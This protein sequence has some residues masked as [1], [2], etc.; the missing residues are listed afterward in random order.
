MIPDTDHL[1]TLSAA[2]REVPNRDSG[3]GVNVS[4]VWRWSLRGIRGVKLQT[5]MRGGIRFT[6]RESLQRFFAA[7]TAAANGE[8]VALGCTSRRHREIEAA[9]K[10]LAEAG[11]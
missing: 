1:L 8:S 11:I 9:E 2:A 4:T 7:T 6:S 10:E 5:E 3:R